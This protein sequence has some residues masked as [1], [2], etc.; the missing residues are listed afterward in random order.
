VAPKPNNPA[1]GFLSPSVVNETFLVYFSGSLKLTVLLFYCWV[2][3]FLFP[4]NEGFY[5]V[6]FGLENVDN[7][8][9]VVFK[10]YFFYTGLLVSANNDGPCGFSVFGYG[11]LLNNV[12]DPCNKLVEGFVYY[13]GVY[14]FFWPNKE[15]VKGAG[16][17]LGV[18]SF[19]YLLVK[20]N[21]PP[22]VYVGLV[23]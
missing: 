21:N 13:F 7:K 16:V 4:N 18:V 3:S 11:A 20:L 1:D 6:S 14:Y 22:V 2:S 10:G 5:T 15:P 9:Y 12:F 23:V 8:G 19:F 17:K